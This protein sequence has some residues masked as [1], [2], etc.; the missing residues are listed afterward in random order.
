MTLQEKDYNPA[1]M[2]GAANS[3]VLPQTIQDNTS[4]ALAVGPNGATN[5]AFQIDAS[6]ASMAAGLKLTGAT[7]AGNVALQVISSGSNANLLIDAKGSGTLKLNNAGS[8]AGLTTIGN[9]T[10]MGGLFVNGPTWGN[11]KVL[12]SSGNTTLTAAMSGSCMLFDSASGVTYTL[13]APVIGQQFDFLVSVSCTSN[14]HKVITDA[15]TTLLAGAVIV[16]VDNTASKTWVGDGASHVAVNM[17]AASTNAKGG[18]FGS[19]LRFVA[20]TSTQ[21]VVSGLAVGGGTSSSPFA[22]S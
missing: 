11:R 16:A 3:S 10:A 20:T 7:A 12:A 22:T 2:Q 21:W 19:W 1:L 8:S 4:S 15:G 6:T 13:P 18:L 14:G 5:P 9:S 17:T